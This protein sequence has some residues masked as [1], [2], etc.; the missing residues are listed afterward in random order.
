M[1]QPKNPRIALICG[2]WHTDVMQLLK[3]S[4]QEKLYKLELQNIEVY[5]AP[6]CLEIPLLAYTVAKRTVNPVDALVALGVVVRGETA[7][8]EYVWRSCS[9]GLM[10]VM[11]DTQKPIGTAVLA[12]ESKQQ[13]E[14]RVDRGADAASAA[15]AMMH[16]MEHARSS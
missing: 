3:Q 13:A 15:V 10:R 2:E 11:L 5:T 14:S 7:H 6:G 16:R 8:F 12:V 4:A 9:D 1:N